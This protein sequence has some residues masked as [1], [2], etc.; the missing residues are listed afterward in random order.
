MNT[1]RKSRTFF[2]KVW[3]RGNATLGWRFDLE[4]R[5]IRKTFEK[6]VS[7]TASILDVGCGYGRNM[8]TLKT[9]GFSNITGLDIN[10]EIVKQNN[11]AG[12]NCLSIQDFQK[13]KARY[14][15]ILMSHV[16]EH[17]AP[18]ALFDFLDTYVNRLNQ[19]GYLIIATPLHSPYFY[20]D[21]DHVKPYQPAGFMQIMG[22]H[23]AQIQ[24]YNKHK[25]ELVDI[26]FRKNSREIRY[27]RSLYIVGFRSTFVYAFNFFSHLMFL[28][29]FCLLGKVDG[30]LGIFRK[31]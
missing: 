13:T 18:D 11:K 26:W 30:W 21:F 16:V 6:Y 14:D 12:L 28:L 5:K 4:T 3:A 17:F 23:G 25:I 29:S 7:P 20:D 27:S 15:V 10:P 19:N 1:L 31:K 2:G 22:G 9:A 24:Y 8:R